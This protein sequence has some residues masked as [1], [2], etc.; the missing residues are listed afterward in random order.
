MQYET[1][2]RDDGGGEK[3]LDEQIIKL[4]NDERQERCGCEHTDT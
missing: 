1:Y 4:L 2:E 3:N